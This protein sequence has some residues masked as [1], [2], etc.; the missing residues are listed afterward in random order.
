LDDRAEGLWRIHDDLYDLTDFVKKHPGGESWIRLTKGTDITEAFEAHHLTKTPE[1][2]LPKFRV[3]SAAQPRLYKFTFAEDGFYRTLKRKVS[4]QLKAMDHSS[5]S[6]TKVSRRYM[7]S[8][9]CRTF[10]LFEILTCNF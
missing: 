8:I 1:T 10:H 2:M 7:G 6:S 9:S 3:R 4:E 5:E